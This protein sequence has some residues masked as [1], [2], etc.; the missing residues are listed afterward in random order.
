MKF[1]TAKNFI[2]RVFSFSHKSYWVNNL[3]RITLVLRKNNFPADII[4]K[5]ISSV[6]ND[7]IKTHS[8]TRAFERS[9]YRF[10]SADG[11]T[12]TAAQQ[13]EN[14]IYS[15]IA[16]VPDLTEQLARSC[17]YFVPEIKAAMR[18]V[19][20]VSSFF[21]NMK[22][23]LPKKENSGLVYKI[24]CKNCDK[25]YIGETIQ[26]LAK[27]LDQHEN[28]CD[29]V[30]S[31]TANLKKV[32]ALAGHTH[33]TNHTFD[34][35]KADILKFERNKFKLQV[36]EVNQIIK[37]EQNVCN[38]KTDKKDY[39]NTYYNLITHAHSNVRSNSNRIT[40]QSSSALV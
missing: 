35:D 30:A 40:A 34:F 22:Q 11:S 23:K 15:A 13:A 31:G 21:A 29:K 20:K 9:S 4:K 14:K 37:H 28:E 6:Q 5:L 7:N 38:F 36:Q 10:L 27:R 18:P 16:Y 32:A 12:I 1:N 8:G 39:T 3:E 25:I 19:H 26:K 17:E 33:E 2:R 24:P